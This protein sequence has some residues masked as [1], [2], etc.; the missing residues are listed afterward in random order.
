MAQY[1]KFTLDRPVDSRSAVL[2]RV[3]L[4]WTELVAKY[5]KDAGENLW[6]FRERSHV[7][8]LAAAAWLSGG[9]AVEEWPMQKKG[10]TGKKATGRGDLW[11]RMGGRLE[12]YVEAKHR[13]ITIGRNV[14]KSIEQTKSALA[15]ASDDA[16]RLRGRR[17]P[18]SR[19]VGILFVS[20]RL[21]KLRADEGVRRLETWGRG[22][23]GT[24]GLLGYAWSGDTTMLRKQ[25]GE[26]N[27]RPGVLLLIREVA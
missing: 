22:L 19:K 14:E 7:S 15:M 6:D 21:N 18:G 11:L 4:S 23:L 2:K 20:P 10:V 8:S 1:P 27:L 13:R 9:V 26:E 3:L 16:K 12:L 17:N 24:K 25:E 5:N